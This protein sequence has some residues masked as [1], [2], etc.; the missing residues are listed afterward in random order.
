MRQCIL[1]VVL[2]WVQME[3]LCRRND[4]ILHRLPQSQNQPPQHHR[5]CFPLYSEGRYIYG[6]QRCS[7]RS[8]ASDVLPDCI[9]QSCLLLCADTF[10]PVY[11]QSMKTS[12]NSVFPNL[13]SS[14][15]QN[16][17]LFLYLL[18]VC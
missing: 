5:C 7:V 10:R 2:I 15:L 3:V 17:Y 13:N 9:A 14:F 18:K 11:P 16:G 4:N 6:T 12:A 8:F 1:H